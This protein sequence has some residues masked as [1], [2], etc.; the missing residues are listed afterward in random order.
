MDSSTQPGPTR[1]RGHRWR[2][3]A[4]CAAYPSLEWIEPSSPH[5]GTCR[6]ICRACPVRRECLA[7]ALD[8]REPWG[9]WG[10]LD[11]RERRE[12]VPHQGTLTR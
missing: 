2:H 12:L 8:T 4:A 6:S 9:I 7:V 10:G 5:I 1:R 11:P 3:R